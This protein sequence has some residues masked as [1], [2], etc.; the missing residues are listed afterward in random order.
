MPL[1]L[2]AVPVVTARAAYLGAKDAGQTDGV[3]YAAVWVI[4][5]A[6]AVGL[7]TVPLIFL[8]SFLAR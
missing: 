8:A 7:L 6:I 1:G 4:A 3:A 5:S 2:V